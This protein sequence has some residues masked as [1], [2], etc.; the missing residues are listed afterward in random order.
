MHAL[1]QACKL[2]KTL[3]HEPLI[4]HSDR[5]SQYNADMFRT[6]LAKRNIRQS[7]SGVGNCYDNAPMESF[8]SRMKH[9][10]RHDMRFDDLRQARTAVYR[11]VHLFY[12]RKRMHSALNYMTPV[13]FEEQHLR[14]HSDRAH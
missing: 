11:W 12:N 10:L 6:E 9:E 13:D 3:P 2:R 8:W 4:F 7:M 1:D 14:K 5:G